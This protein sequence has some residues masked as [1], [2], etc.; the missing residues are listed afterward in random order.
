MTQI[1]QTTSVDSIVSEGIIIEIDKEGMIHVEIENMDE[2]IPCYFLETDGA[3]P[4]L[5]IGD[6]VAIVLNSQNRNGYVLGKVSLYRPHKQSPSGKTV[7]DSRHQNTSVKRNKGKLV[8]EADQEIELKCGKSSFSMDR[9][10]KIVV[11]GENVTNRA[12]QMNKIK[13]GSVQVN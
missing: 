11:R 8:I 4:V 5:K 10:G 3:L 7:L 6:I 9:D 13:G 2:P 1:S 12:K